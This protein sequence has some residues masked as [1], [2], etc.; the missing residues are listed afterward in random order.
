MEE[1]SKMI[2]KTNPAQHQGKVRERYKISFPLLIYISAQEITFLQ[3]FLKQ[4][5]KKESFQILNY[6]NNKLKIPFLK[7][8]RQPICFTSVKISIILHKKDGDCS[9]ISILF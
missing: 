4:N 1:I 9:A 2:L 7:Y 8:H 6:N 3:I 5:I